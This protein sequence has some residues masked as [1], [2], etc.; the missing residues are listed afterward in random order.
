MRRKIATRRKSNSSQR[1]YHNGKGYK[2]E[3]SKFRSNYLIYV[4]KINNFNNSTN[5]FSN[6]MVLISS[7]YLLW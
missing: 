4:N 1:N 5:K 3:F 2:Q 6:K 7:R